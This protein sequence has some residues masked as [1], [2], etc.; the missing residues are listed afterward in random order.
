MQKPWL[1]KILALLLAT[2]A[3]NSANA[4]QDFDESLFVANSGADSG[5]CG[6][7][8]SPCRTIGYVIQHAVPGS[9]ILVAAGQYEISDAGDLFF[10]VNG[11]ANI[12]GGFDAMDGF[13]QTSDGVTTL[14]GVPHEYRTQ[15]SGLGF[16]VVAEAKSV[17]DDI[18]TGTAVP[19]K[20]LPSSQGNLSTAPCIGGQ[21]SGLEC[22]NAELLSRVANSSISAVPG[23]ASDVWGFT[24]LN[25]NREYVIV[26]YNTGTAV[27]DV[28]DPESPA[29]VGFIAG[30][31]TSWRDIAIY[32]F[33]NSVE[34]RWNAFAYV[35]SEATSEGLFVI[36]L[37]QLPQSVARRNFVSEYG[38][39]HNVY[40]TNTDFSTGLGLSLAVPSLIVGGAALDGG[41]F[42]SYSLA[43][44]ATPQ[45]NA[46]GSGGGDLYMHDAV[47]AVITDSRKDQC[48]NETPDYC[49]LLFDFNEG[50]IVIWDITNSATPF[51]LQEISYGGAQ[52]T[53]SGWVS[54]D[55]RFLFVH[56]ELDERNLG[57]NTTLRV[58][59]LDT[60][61][62]VLFAGSWVST[63]VTTDHNGFVRGNRYY[64][65]NYKRGLTILDITDPANPTESGYLDTFT[66]PD[67]SG[68]VFQGAWGAY[69][70]L[71]SGSIAISDISNGLHMIRDNSLAVAQGSLSFAQ[72]SFA[73]TEGSDVTVTVQRVGGSSGTVSVDYALVPGTADGADLAGM[74]G[75][76]SWT[77]GDLTDKTIT[78][79]T[80]R[81]NEPNEALERMFIK[82]IAPTG[83]ATLSPGSMASVYIGEDSTSSVEF[84][85]NAFDVA[86]LGFGKAIVIVQRRGSAI[87]AVSVDYRIS[88]GDALGGIDYQGSASGTLNWVSGN[89]DPKWIEFPIVDDGSGEADEFFE[90]T[91]SNTSGATVGTTNSVR[92]T[93]LDGSG[94]DQ[95]PN[96]QPGGGQTV[97]S[98]GG[99]GTIGLFFLTLFGSLALSRRTT[100]R[101]GVA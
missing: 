50:S 35:I 2:V 22:L 61:N 73:A 82:L 25:S 62:A 89:A 36:D 42:R 14:V 87:G 66:P 17:K 30:Q 39:A 45:L 84:D 1:T 88:N 52:Y 26:G 34:N 57:T 72:S 51:L 75:T 97:Q 96:P 29:E 4:Q 101:K 32:Q 44:P 8:E 74:T 15:L 23:A 18:L 90:L 33:F 40:L 58:F 98:G 85:R 10:L 95:P 12:R 24:D 92:V 77:N 54:E 79:S 86:E 28:T 11:A 37:S 67:N 83:G 31:T 76:L 93:I 19:Q 64:M 65:S 69:P 7:P 94:I 59:S 47:S 78:L 41:R 13:R 27:I 55:K 91:L 49:E 81:D 43:N 38:A 60:L 56:D 46:V 53:H 63:N 21:S 5:R 20:L 80:L 16:H 99:G 70:F 3:I 9:R 48:Q 100:T 68:S 71:P 6:N